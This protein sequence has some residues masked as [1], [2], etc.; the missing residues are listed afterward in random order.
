MNQLI[1][2]Y[3]GCHLKAYKCPKGI[4]TI[5]WGNTIYQ[6]GKPIKEG[7]TITQVQADALME[8]HCKTQ[9]KI[10]AGLKSKQ[11]EAV[12]SLIFNIGQGAFDRS[13]LK[14]AIEKK[15]WAEVFRQWDWVGSPFLRGLALRRAGEL[16]SFFSEP[17]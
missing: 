9:I 5:G 7:D 14:T 1:K 16:L 8:W 15:D 3:E 12:Q 17:L 13:K 11:A 4:W 6:D 2:K 10:P